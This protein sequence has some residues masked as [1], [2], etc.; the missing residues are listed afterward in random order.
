[1]YIVHTKG[2]PPSGNEN[3]FNSLVNNVHPTKKPKICSDVLGSPGKNLGS[4]TGVLTVST[5]L[6]CYIVYLFSA[7]TQQC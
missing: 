3:L 2:T 7:T 6:W 1:M 5:I 4:Y